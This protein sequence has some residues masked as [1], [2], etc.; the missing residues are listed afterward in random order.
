M[1]E[2]SKALPPKADQSYS[3]IGGFLVGVITTHK[4]GK[5]CSFSRLMKLDCNLLADAVSGLTAGNSG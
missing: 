4:R 2:C 3:Q 5:S 1:T